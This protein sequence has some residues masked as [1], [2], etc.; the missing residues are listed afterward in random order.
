[1]RGKS[2]RTQCVVPGLASRQSHPK[3]LALIRAGG[4]R[5]VGAGIVDDLD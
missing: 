1:M 5:G 2:L 4:Q 3:V